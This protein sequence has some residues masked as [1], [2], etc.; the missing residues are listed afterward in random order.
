MLNWRD[1]FT[2]NNEDIDKQ[3][4]RLFELIND[5]YGFVKVKDGHDRYD[6]IV[7]IFR[8][9][10]DYTVYHF[11]HEEGLFE[12][13]G[14]DPINTKL[15]KL[16]HKSFINKVSEIDLDKVDEN[17]RGIS[18]EVVLFA[19]KWVEQHILDTDLKFAAFLKAM[20]S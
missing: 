10:S 17:Q 4:K 7:D 20:N 15:H 8:E 6:E 12:K 5:L 3:H 2:C 9:L 19:A 11:G 18:M 13:H 14:Y 16:E 1:E